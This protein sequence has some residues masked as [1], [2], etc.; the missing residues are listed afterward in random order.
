VDEG[1]LPNLVVIGAQ[2][3]GTSSLH[4]YLDLHPEIEMSRAKELDFFLADRNLSRGVDWYAGQF[5]GRTPVRGES[6][7]NYTNLPASAGVAERMSAL[8]G[9]ARLI[10][11]V[12]DPI[13]RA[14][15]HYVHAVSLGRE[16]RSV[17]EALSDPESSY[18]RRSLYRTQLEP[19]V[20]RFGI[21]RLL[22]A[23]QEDLLASREST[24]RRVFA[25]L[26][27]DESFTSPEFERR[28]EVSAGKDRKF[29]LA[30][31]ISRRIGDKDFWGRLPPGLRWRLER[32]ASGRVGKRVRPPELSDRVRAEL[33]RRFAPE[34]E[35]LRRLTGG[36][37]AGWSP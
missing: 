23:S 18:V 20:V 34:V 14:L 28:W 17:D 12:R 7:P 10:Y 15:S 4:R 2:K 36:G 26:G 16:R 21:E 19:F 25:F 31:R 37:P 22:V 9:D 3:C 11:L 1:S 5:S 13:E 6:S 29:R 33:A 27:V 8:I 32:V 24:L 35:D 30:Y